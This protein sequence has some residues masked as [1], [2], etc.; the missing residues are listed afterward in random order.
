MARVHKGFLTA[1]ACLVVLSIAGCG[2]DLSR[3][4]ARRQISKKL[5]LPAVQTMLIPRRA[6]N[7]ATGARGTGFM[8]TVTICQDLSSS[9]SDVREEMESLRGKG[10]VTLGRQLEQ[11]GNCTYDYTTISLS[12]EGQRFLVSESE[13][14]YTVRTHTVT[15]GE[16][17]G[18][19]LINEV[20]MAEAQ[21]T[22]RVED[23]TPF[24]RDLSSN[25]VS[26]S[27]MF[28]LFDD[29]WRIE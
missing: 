16:V 7:S 18:I 24:R 2:N 22:L 10:L 19:R 27:A 15:F 9:W 8:P 26:Q 25:P 6:L 13:E 11:G 17:T 29:G 12:A 14:G 3:G 23:V 1:T 28:E 20:K 4:D 21:Y 5:G